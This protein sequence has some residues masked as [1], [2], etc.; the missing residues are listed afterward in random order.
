MD[1]SKDISIENVNLSVPNKQLLVNTKLKIAY[2]R[3]YALIGH[4]GLG[5]STLLKQINDKIIP[6]P[7][8]IDIFYVDQEIDFDGDEDLI[9]FDRSGNKINLF[10]NV[11]SS[12]H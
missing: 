7:S 1:N 4:N 12:Y 6:V 9:V 5:K 8:N 3:K 11:N 10:K 2:G